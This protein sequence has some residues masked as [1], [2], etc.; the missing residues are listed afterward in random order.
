M[1]ARRKYLRMMNIRMQAAC[2]RCRSRDRGCAR[3]CDGERSGCVFESVVLLFLA[4]EQGAEPVTG[5]VSTDE[6]GL[7]RV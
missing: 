6:T 2:L 7:V 3:T 5:Y 1:K 4:V